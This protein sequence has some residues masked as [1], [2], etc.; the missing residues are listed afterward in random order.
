MKSFIVKPTL[1]CLVSLLGL[2]TIACGQLEELSS[3]GERTAQS[4]SNETDDQE[5]LINSSLTEATGSSEPSLRPFSVGSA[6]AGKLPPGGHGKHGPRGRPGPHHPHGAKL[7]SPLPADILAL[8]KAADAKKNSVLGIDRAKVDEIL[9]ALQTEL[10]ALRAV[11][12]SREEFIAN[13]K[14][15]QEKY[16]AQ[17]RSVLP[18]FESL[19]QE[20][21]DRV[22]S[23][24]DQQKAVIQSC[25][26]VG[27]DPAA[28][29][30]TAAKAALQAS[31][32]AP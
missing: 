24:H 5:N 29:A 12:A 8:M 20:Q 21:K 30:C 19:S 31:I 13:A 9:K 1:W 16:T 4:E 23:I 7:V 22:K 6:E 26:V 32:D 14:P 18:A 25:A 2:G 17:L 28:A 3:R 27:A 11:S 10:V 15:I